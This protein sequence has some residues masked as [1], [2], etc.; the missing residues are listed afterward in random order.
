MSVPSSVSLHAAA[1]G[2]DEVFPELKDRAEPDPP[3][4][5]LCHFIVT[6]SD[7][8]AKRFE[9]YLRTPEDSR[10]LQRVCILFELLYFFLHLA[11]RVALQKLGE[12]GL[13]RLRPELHPIVITSAVYRFFAHWEERYKSEI[14]RGFYEKF[15]D[16]ETEY[17][18]CTVLMS[19]ASPL[20]ETALCS[21][22]A[23]N[24]LYLSG[25]SLDIEPLPDDHLEFAG[26]V[27]TRVR[28]I[29]NATNLIDLVE[30]AGKSVGSPLANTV[31]TTSP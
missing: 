7:Q 20:D 26:L 28:D 27:Q 30:Q 3:L 5:S 16:A 1:S 14:E 19:N 22:L 2:S 17:G 8:C 24:I 21:R 4:E 25:Y 12:D 29:L 15:S 10:E 11:D 23:R 9:P 18:S 6:A 31:S 13:S